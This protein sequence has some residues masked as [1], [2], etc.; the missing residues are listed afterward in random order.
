MGRT[1]SLLDSLFGGECCRSRGT[2]RR[3]SAR[4]GPHAHSSVCQLCRPTKPT[5]HCDGLVAVPVDDTE[6]VR[7]GGQSGRQR[8]PINRNNN[9]HTTTT[10]TRSANR[11]VANH[12]LPGQSTHCRDGRMEQ[13]YH[14]RRHYHGNRILHRVRQHQRTFGPVP[15]LAG[16]ADDTRGM[17]ASPRPLLFQLRIRQ[18]RHQGCRRTGHH[19]GQQSRG[20]RRHNLARS[21]HD[22]ARH[23]QTTTPT[24]TLR[25]RHDAGTHTHTGHR[26]TRRTR[27]IIPD[28]TRHQHSL[29]NGH[30]WYARVRQGTLVRRIAL[31]LADHSGQ[32]QHCR[33]CCR[34]HYHTSRSH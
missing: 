11:H 2:H 28:Y 20:S 4:Y 3:V 6:S 29:R 5:K 12:S 21:H 34:R 27:S 17:R 33:I 24:R 13:Y 30:G 19:L 10:T 22:T 15:T 31:F 9:I 16:R 7:I 26:R 25:T 1:S 8:T 14:H 23:A 18:G 32:F